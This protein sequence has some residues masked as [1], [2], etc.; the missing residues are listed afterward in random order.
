MVD[1]DAVSFIGSP[2][3]D[4]VYFRPLPGG[5]GREQR[6]SRVARARFE[7]ADASLNLCLGVVTGYAAKVLFSTCTTVARS[8]AQT[9]RASREPG[10]N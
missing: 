8:K 3:I 2:L 4:L 9:A 6:S 1:T 5:T 10:D 7:S